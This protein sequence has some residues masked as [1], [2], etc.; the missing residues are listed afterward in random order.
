MKL[1]YNEVKKL[2]IRNRAKFK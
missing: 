2:E 1:E